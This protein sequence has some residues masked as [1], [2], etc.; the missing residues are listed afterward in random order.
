M[1]KQKIIRRLFF[2]VLSAVHALCGGG[3]G[4][5]A[6]TG[7]NA[8]CLRSRR[9]SADCGLGGYFYRIPRGVAVLLIV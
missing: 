7:R 4:S 6:R 2:G 1:K 9:I 8:P 5:Q 3:G